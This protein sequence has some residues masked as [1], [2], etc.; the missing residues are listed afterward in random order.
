L[1]PQAAELRDPEQRDDGHR[2]HRTDGRVED[3]LGQDGAEE[4][5][6]QR[7][8][9]GRDRTAESSTSTALAMTVMWSLA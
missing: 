9:R 7:S 6:Q 2:D 4:D 3:V 5:Q 8:C 1:G